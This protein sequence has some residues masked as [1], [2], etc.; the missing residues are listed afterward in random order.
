VQFSADLFMVNK[1][2]D[3]GLKAILYERQAASG[4]IHGATRVG[5]M[6]VTDRR[7]FEDP[8]PLITKQKRDF[9]RIC[10]ALL[11]APVS[12]LEAWLHVCRSGS[13]LGPHNHLV[14]DRPGEL[15]FTM[16]YY[17]SRGDDNGTGQL[18]LSRPD[19]LIHPKDGMLILFPS[20]VDHE[21]LEY[22]GQSDRIVIGCN[23]ERA[24]PVP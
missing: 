14:P 1:P 9:S 5:D 8:H 22:R 15:Q 20:S 17:V 18:R 12:V 7:L 11:G 19:M 10:A 6:H 24:P 13:A 2:V 21:V 16:S 3:A 4:G 23:L